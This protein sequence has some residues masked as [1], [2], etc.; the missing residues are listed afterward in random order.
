[1]SPKGSTAAGKAK[2]AAASDRKQ[3]TL[4]F[5]VQLLMPNRDS[6]AQSKSK[7]QRAEAGDE[8]VAE[9]RSTRFAISDY[10]SSVIN[11][12]I[13]RFLLPL[14]A[15]QTVDEVVKEVKSKRIKYTPVQKSNLLH[16][17][18]DL[19]DDARA[20][21]CPTRAAT[22]KRINMIPGYQ[23]VTAKMVGEWSK[24]TVANKSGPKVNWGFEEQVIAQLVYT[25]Y[26]TVDNVEQAVIVA[27]VAHSHDVIRQAARIASKMPA[28]TDNLLIQRLKFTRPWIRAFL[29]RA[30]L[31]KR[32]ITTIDKKLPSV[33]EVR[34]RMGEIQKVIVDGDFSADETI[35]ADETG[36]MFGAPPKLQYIPKSAD[37]AVA[38]ESDEKARFTALLWGMANGEM[39]PAFIIIKMSVKG[40]DLSSQRTLQGLQKKGYS[41]ADGWQLRTWS[42]SLTLAVKK[43]MVT[44]KFVRPY[45]I[46]LATGVIITVQK[47]AWMD[48][49]GVCMWADVQLGPIFALKRNKCCVVW[50][51]CGPHK[52]PAVCDVL[53]SWNITAE[54]LPKNI[55]D[56]LQVMD[57]VV[58]GPVKS[59]I[60]RRRIQSV[61]NYFQSFKIQ[62]LQHNVANGP[63][64]AFTPPRPTQAEGITT[65]LKVLKEELTRDSFKDSMRRCFINV[66]LWKAAGASDF[67]IYT[68]AK[69]GIMQQIIRP[70]HSSDDAVTVGEIAAEVALTTRPA[71]DAAA[72]LLLLATGAGPSEDPG[73]DSSAEEGESG[74]DAEDSDMHDHEDMDF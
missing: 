53:S 35:S 33:Q 58:N 22:M 47:K 71:D 56:S 61:F 23:H 70:A 64:P 68:R 25:A 17:V 37:R 30:A 31:R 34:T 74:S 43:A 44:T 4:S 24:C 28:F 10:V 59:G 7:R 69:K 46:H 2:M 15:K 55:T 50:D 49:P 21:C 38:P 32:R 40:P 29:R 13:Q 39:G 36:V 27:N 66:G 19:E 18:A 65:V 73:E 63:P 14:G 5:G 12:G 1:M 3:S 45:L 57:L 60:R 41:E 8:A 11:S 16:L 62:R 67:A 26:E 51:N 42:R 72:G 54:A 52:V 9:D 6:T 20:D 48:T